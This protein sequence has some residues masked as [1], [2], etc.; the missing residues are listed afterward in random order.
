MAFCHGE[1]TRGWGKL[2]SAHGMVVESQ[3]KLTMK[4]KLNTHAKDATAREAQSLPL[5]AVRRSASDASM[6]PSLRR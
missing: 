6:G 5:A 4:A 2:E 3:A 1:G